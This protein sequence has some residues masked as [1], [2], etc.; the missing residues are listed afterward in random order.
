MQNGASGTLIIFPGALGDLICLEPTLHALVRRHGESLELMARAE[1]A[2]FA[3]GR[4]GIAAGHSI[5]RREMSLLFAGDAAQ[6]PARKFFGKF[7]RVYSFFASDNETFRGALAAA[8]AGPVSFHSFRPPGA[9][10]VG[11]GYLRSIGEEAAVPPRA[12]IK[13]SP[14]DI[15][16]ASRHLARMGIRPGE[17][18]LIFP[19]SG[20]PGKNW[21]GE[22]YAAL[23]GRLRDKIAPIVIIGPAEYES[24]AFFESRGLAV[25]SE[26]ELGEVAGIAAMA[27]CFVGNDS[28][29]S[30]LAAAAGARGVVLFGPTDP[31][32]WAPLGDVATIRRDPL[33]AITPDEAFASLANMLRC[34]RQ[35]STAS[36]WRPK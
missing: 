7:G 27:R 15:A 30:H 28:G 17:F 25:M 33:G 14:E 26:L 20:S 34:R 13:P 12:R 23:A 11:Q 9:G 29:V 19:G 1:L 8:A 6:A 4:M 32:R 18:A 3:V 22:N 21:P 2:R 31:A 5:D 16:A 35:G 36:L 10:H 24:R